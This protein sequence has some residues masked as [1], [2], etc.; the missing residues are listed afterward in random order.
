MGAVRFKADMYKQG[1]FL[2]ALVF[3][4]TS[5]RSS[6][7][8]TAEDPPPVTEKAA[9]GE[10]D[11]KVTDA[12]VEPAGG[13]DDGGDGNGGGEAPMVTPGNLDKAIEAMNT[14]NDLFEKIVNTI[15]PETDETNDEPSVDPPVQ[16]DIKPEV[17]SSNETEA[18][19]PK[20]NTKEPDPE[21]PDDA[22]KPA[23][24]LGNQSSQNT[25]FQ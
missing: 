2:I 5:V 19:A 14:L 6:P 25:H 11:K 13:A 1:L 17:G 20:E 16:E 9:G 22:K 23:A 24:Q 3:L 15:N 12:P 4:S 10:E 8:K 21:K 18:P 7:L